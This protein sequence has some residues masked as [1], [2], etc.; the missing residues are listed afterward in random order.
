MVIFGSKGNRVTVFVES[1]L[2]ISVTDDDFDFDFGSSY[3]ASFD[4]DLN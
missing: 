4:L 1:K 3:A 2:L